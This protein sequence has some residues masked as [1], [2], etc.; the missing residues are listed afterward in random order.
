MA[1]YREYSCEQEMLLPVSLT[2]QIQPGTFEYT[3]NYVVDH[4]IDLRVFES[5][6]RND[7]TGA[8][9]IDPAILLEAILLAYSRGNISS[10]R[11][12]GVRRECAVHGT[13]GGHPTAFHDDCPVHLLDGRA[14]HL[15]VRSHEAHLGDGSVHA[16]RQSEGRH[17]V[18]AVLRGAQHREDPK[19]RNRL[20]GGQSQ[21]GDRPRA[22]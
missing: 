3:V 5:R 6:Y 8:P 9:A 20:A 18:E 13:G 2:Q 14:D 11:I 15:G 17:S 7:D 12:A 10:R 4:E 1:K 21:T 22:V 16:S 19:V